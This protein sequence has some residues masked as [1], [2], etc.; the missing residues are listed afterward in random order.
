LF[1]VLAVSGCEDKQRAV[2]ADQQPAAESPATKSAA[3]RVAKAAALPSGGAEEVPQIEAQEDVSSESY[4]LPADD[5][6]AEVDL[7][8]VEIRLEPT[9]N[10]HAAA[11]QLAYLRAVNASW[12]AREF[13]A[14]EA[15][16]AGAGDAVDNSAPSQ[17]QP[18][19]A[20]EA[21]S[22]P[23]AHPVGEM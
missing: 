17:P 8:N 11:S 1:A 15:A 12:Q 14:A 9:T 2:E 21:A 16:N 10:I 13:Q 22:A 6:L 7:E 4:S 19:A 5:P 3:P 20:S 18:E 23:L